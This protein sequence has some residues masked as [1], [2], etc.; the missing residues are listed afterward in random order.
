[1][2]VEIWTERMSE[3]QSRPGRLASKFLDVGLPLFLSVLVTGCFVLAALAPTA[4][5]HTP[6]PQLLGAAAFLL[7]SVFEDLRRMRIPN[8]L[9]FPALALALLLALATGG[10]AALLTALAGAGLA[11]LLFV[12]PFAFGLFGAGDVKAMMVFGA[13]FGSQLIIAMAWWMMIVGGLLAIALVA[14]QPGGLRDLVVRWSK[15]AWFTLR[16]RKLTYLRPELDSAAAS[17]LPYAVAMGIGA[18]ACQLWGVPWA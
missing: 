15:S 1:M 3:A 4:V 17:G 11:L 8:F 7:P 5:H 13:L 10:P 16:L 9:T 14:A 12:C 18:S 2:S 6:L